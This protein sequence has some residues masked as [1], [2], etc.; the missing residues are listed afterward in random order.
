[1]K[2]GFFRA[3]ARNRTRNRYYFFCFVK[4]TIPITMDYNPAFDAGL[5]STKEFFA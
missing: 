5:S 2:S 1:M 4:K 3:R